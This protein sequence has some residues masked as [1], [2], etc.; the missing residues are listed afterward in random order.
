MNL[1]NLIKKFY[2][3]KGKITWKKLNINSPSRRHLNLDK[4]KKIGFVQ[5]VSIDKGI[6]ETVEWFIKNYNNKKLRK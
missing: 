4:L 3:Y 6:Q 1:V 2:K 5:K